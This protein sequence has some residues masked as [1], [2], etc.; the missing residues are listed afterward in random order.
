[1]IYGLGPMVLIEG[2]VDIK[3]MPLVPLVDGIDGLDTL[4]ETLDPHILG[5]FLNK[6]KGSLKISLTWTSMGVSVLVKG[7]LNLG[8]GISSTTSTSMKL[9]SLNQT[10]KNETLQ[11]LGHL[12]RVT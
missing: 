4:D 9:V 1:V 10:N 12:F 7:V 2:N 3:G 6:E 11:I 8:G 5:G